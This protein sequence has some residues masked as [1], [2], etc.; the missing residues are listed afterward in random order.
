MNNVK[1]ILIG[2]LLAT[3][4]QCLLGA[5]IAVVVNKDNPVDD[6]SLK[7]LTAIFELK[8]QNWRGSEQIYL[9]LLKSGQVESDI[10]LDKVYRRSDAAMIK[11]WK[12][13]QFNGLG[14][15]PKKWS[16]SADAKIVVSKVP[17]SIGYI[18]A[19]EVDDTVKVLSVDGLFPGDDDYLL[20]QD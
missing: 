1:A 6:V 10:V 11:F 20:K 8:K 19:S 15:I 5:E 3:G 18:D 2:L 13:I 17:K 16:S 14:K 9:V 7:E 12:N 4:T